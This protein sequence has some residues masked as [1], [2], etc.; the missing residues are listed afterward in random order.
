VTRAAPDRAH[1]IAELLN[2]YEL[3]AALLAA[4]DVRGWTFSSRCTGW[5]VR[6]VAAH[7]VGQAADVVSGAAGTRTPDQQATALRDQPPSALADRLLAAQ[8]SVRGLVTG[9]D[10]A[11]WDA[12][13]AIPDLTV[14]QGIQT[15]VHDVYVHGDDIRA[16][17]R[18][19]F[20]AGPGLSASLDF[21]LGALERGLK[22]DNVA[23]A[24]PRI[25]G[26]LPIPA[27]EFASATGIDSHDFVLAA[28][29]R[30]DA[31]RLDL[32]DSINIYR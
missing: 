27:N 4:V 24:D 6:D 20:D 31:A 29:G 25:T 14:G 19:P 13:S 26:L 32:P 11:G 23:S 17:L 10:D 8:E 30:L 21:V 15:L 28:T 16:A 1:T 2:Q 18:L 5:Q 7:V 12:P 3:F 22:R 9:L